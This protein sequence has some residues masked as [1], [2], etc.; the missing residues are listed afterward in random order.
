MYCRCGSGL[1]GEALSEAGHQWIGI[2][3]SR[4][5]LS[6]YTYKV[7][8]TLSRSRGNDVLTHKIIAADVAKEREVDGDLFIWDM[9]D[10]LGFRPGTFDGAI[11]FVPKSLL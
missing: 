3:I 7:V 1:S 4:A 5:M 9:G 2:D 8:T 6:K 11:R 10:G